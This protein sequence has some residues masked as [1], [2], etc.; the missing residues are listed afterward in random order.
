MDMRPSP[1]PVRRACLRIA[2]V[3][4]L[5]IFAN[6]ALAAAPEEPAMHRA[7]GSFDVKITPEADTTAETG[8]ARLR[9]DKR[10]RGALDATAIGTMLGSTTAVKGSAGYVAI[11]RVAGI[12]DGRSGSFVLQHF[13]A[14]QGDQRDLDIRVVPDSADGDL[15]GLRGRMQIRIETGGAHFYTFEYTLPDD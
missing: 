8:S 14:M 7:A 5:T 6:A 11:E 1:S 10:Y 4:A 12:L 2:L 3:G 15:T 9:L 13:G